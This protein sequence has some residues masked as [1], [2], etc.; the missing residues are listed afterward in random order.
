MAASTQDP[1]GKEGLA[2]LMDGLFDEGAG[3]LDSEAFQ[4]SW[5]M[6]AP[7]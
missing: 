6:P 1:P 3:D 4:A 2:N 7:K 5:T